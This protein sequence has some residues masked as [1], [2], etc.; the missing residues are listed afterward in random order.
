MAGPPDRLFQKPPNPVNM[1]LVDTAAG[2]GGKAL[3]ASLAA[4]DVMLCCQD[5][6]FHYRQLR[7]DQTRACMPNGIRIL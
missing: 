1:V 3:P 7:F 6:F 5:Q 4:Q 2:N